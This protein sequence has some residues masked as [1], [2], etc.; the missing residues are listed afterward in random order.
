MSQDRFLQPAIVSSSPERLDELLAVTQ[1]RDWLA[2]VAILLLLALALG[3]GTQGR[4]TT[5]VDGQGILV[6]AGGVVNVIADGAGRVLSVN[7]HT[8]DRVQADQVVGTIS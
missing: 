7:V 3:W 4:I 6:L 5:K 8:G 1:P 2:V